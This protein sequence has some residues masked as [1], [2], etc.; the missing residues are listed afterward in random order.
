M[1]GKDAG[2]AYILG[3]SYAKAKQSSSVLKKLAVNV[4]FAFMNTNC[5]GTD[6]VVNLP[7]TS[8]LQIGMDF[9]AFIATDSEHEGESDSVD[10]DP[11]GHYNSS[12]YQ[13]D[14]DIDIHHDKDS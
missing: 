1:E 6:V 2:V 12:H 7:H 13:S 11:T 10:L 5:R 8:L 9:M 4:M 14:D 3:K